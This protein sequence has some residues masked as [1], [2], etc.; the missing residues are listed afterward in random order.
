MSDF[1]NLCKHI[2]SDE[3]YASVLDA[4][5]TATLMRM[6]EKATDEL[7]RAR[8]GLARRDSQTRAALNNVV[9][10]ANPHR[11][12]AVETV[13]SASAALDQARA[14]LT[15]FLN[16]NPIPEITNTENI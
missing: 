2:R 7:L 11:P 3:A 5:M 1:D 16:D 6:E 10:L 4:F 8:A 9:Q 12:C 13:L 14:I 15:A